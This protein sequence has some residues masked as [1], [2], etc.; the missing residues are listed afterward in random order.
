LDDLAAVPE[1]GGGGHGQA[2]LTGERTGAGRG[3]L[4]VLQ[5]VTSVRLDGLRGVVV[6][7]DA[8]EEVEQVI[9]RWLGRPVCA[10]MGHTLLVTDGSVDRDGEVPIPVRAVCPRV[11]FLTAK[12]SAPT[13][14]LGVV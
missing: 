4:Q 14:R 7:R 10:V 5:V 1:G 9:G 2:G 6:V 13:R 11:S 8:A 3:G 12:I